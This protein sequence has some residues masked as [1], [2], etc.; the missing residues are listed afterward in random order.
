M[1]Y[2]WLL[3]TVCYMFVVVEVHWEVKQNTYQV[4]VGQKDCV[5]AA[6]VLGP[7]FISHATNQGASADDNWRCRLADFDLCQHQILLQSS[8]CALGKLSQH[9]MC[10][11]YLGF[12]HTRSLWTLYSLIRHA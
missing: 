9:P 10:A 5:A 8:S 1:R 12:F 6:A 7:Y 2:V 11:F 3:D 4:V